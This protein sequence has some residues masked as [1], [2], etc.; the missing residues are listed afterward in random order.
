[1]PA[2]VDFVLITALEEE[3][4]AVLS[5]L[6]GWRQLP[7]NKD[8]TRVYYS[9]TVE[10]RYG[11]ESCTY[12]VIVCMVGMGRVTA[13]AGTNDAIRRWA[14]DYVILIGI[15]GGL[16]TAGVSLGDILI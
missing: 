11:E 3:R 4:D 6:P 12:S 15:A 13:T 7:P 2:P 14:P 8:D 5:R 10:A 1:M 16:K 9:A